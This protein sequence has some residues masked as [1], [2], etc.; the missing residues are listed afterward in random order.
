MP[1]KL[2]PLAA[3]LFVSCGPEPTPPTEPAELPP[4][5]TAGRL[6]DDAAKYKG[7]PVR[8]YASPRP[9][10]PDC[11]SVTWSGGPRSP[12]VLRFAP[13]ARRP[14]GAAGYATGVCEGTATARVAG[15]E[16]TPPFVLVTGCQWEPEKQ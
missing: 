8:V 7:K 12:V 6:S 14:G 4:T 11:W 10:G 5:L 13:D 1:R 15:V 16:T 9:C 3:A 2:L